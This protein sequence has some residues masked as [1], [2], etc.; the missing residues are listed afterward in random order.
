MFVKC[1]QFLLF[2]EDGGIERQGVFPK[3]FGG[4]EQ[5]LDGTGYGKTDIKYTGG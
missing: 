2:I 3:S 4:G 1:A 5:N